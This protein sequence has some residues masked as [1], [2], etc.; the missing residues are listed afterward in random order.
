MSASA[1]TTHLIGDHLRAGWAAALLVC[2]LVTLTV[3]LVALVPR[4]FS[5]VTTAELRHQLSAAP[6]EQLNL[7]GSGPIGLPSVSNATAE[8]LLGPTDA[9]IAKMSSQLPRPLRDGIGAPDWLLRSVGIAGSTPKS[10]SV[11]AISLAIDLNWAHH[12]RFVSGEEPRAFERV[13]TQDENP[14]PIEIALSSRT[15][16]SI[17]VEAGDVLDSGIGPYLV[18]GIYEPSTADDSYWRHATDLNSPIELRRPGEP[19]KIQ[20]SAFVNPG[21]IVG[22]REIF[23]SGTI[24]AWAPIDPNAYSYAD[25]DQLSMQSG[26]LVA[27]LRD[28]PDFGRLGFSTALPELL[29]RARQAVS[30]MSALIALA[31][32]GL[33]GMLIATYALSIQALLRRRHLA[34]GLLSARGAAPAQLRGVAVL[35][36]ALVALPGSALAIAAAALVV[37]ERVGLEGWLP[38]VALALT[39]LLMA[40]WLVA[41]GSLRESRRD[42]A[43]RSSFALRWVIEVSVAG[44]AAIA[45]VLLQRRGLVASSD[46]TGIDPLLAATPLLLAV[47]A[48][49]IALRLYPLAMRMTLAMARARSA[50]VW[51]VGSARAVREPAIGS[52]ATL[53]LAIGVTIVVFTIVMISTV[54]ATMENAVR[55]RLGADVLVTAHDLPDSVVDDIRQVPGVDGAAALTSLSGLTLTDQAGP[56]T[57]TVLLADPAALRNVRPDLPELTGAPAGTLPILVSAELAKRI[58][59]TEVTIEESRLSTVGVVADSALPKPIGPWLIAD[60]SAA[61]GLGLGGQVPSRI[62]IA[63]SD[64]GGDATVAAITGIV[65]SAQSAQYLASARVTDVRSEL[66]QNRAEPI[67][68]AVEASLVIA[69]GGSLLLTALVVILASAA[70]AAS[71]NRVV[72]ILRILGMTGRQVRGLVAWEFGP[73]VIASIIVGTLVGIGIPFLVTSVLD[74]R[75]FFGGTALPSPTIAPLWIAGAVGVYAIAV[76][77]AVLVASALGRRFA[78][79][80][81]L[82]MGE[83]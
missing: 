18:S 73:A 9:A 2:L 22:L 30:A 61:V 78:P 48:G 80:A 39:P 49:L 33:L 42:I 63:L 62:L 37:P 17:G 27:S 81:T 19:G 67:T 10:P 41:P 64:H 40:G 70:S 72:G 4:M 31:A 57:V 74:L 29:E 71:R 53:A 15:A 75:G 6:P 21:T 13:S 3:F 58:Q 7:T 34:L 1:R 65:L 20:A 25:L 45:L 79:A 23:A 24:T 43:V 68:F 54:G 38:P 35:E 47:T 50:P 28:L 51:A 83:P 69:A 32:S 76:V 56:I 82:K 55:E 8:T 52:I 16:A 60:R 59:G 66:A 46:I 12:V 26:I 77:G 14:N 5:A 44:A 36:A 11:L